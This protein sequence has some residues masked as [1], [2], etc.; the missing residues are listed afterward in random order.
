MKK[1]KKNKTSSLSILSMAGVTHYKIK[2]NEQYM[3]EKQKEHFKKI[4]LAWKYQLTNEVYKTISYMKEEATNFPDP[5][6]RATQ[7]EEFS[8][9]LRNRDR[10]R[11]LIKKIEITLNKLKKN[12]FG[13]CESCNI[14]IGIK[15]LE[16]RPT[17]NLCIDCKT[18]AEI[19][20]KQLLG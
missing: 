6:D 14:E 3:N 16:A 10:E 1:Q 9:E 8:L 12:N 18:L 2:K 5:I 17:A 11:K 13:Y 20:E 4:L 7:E 15:R 19:R